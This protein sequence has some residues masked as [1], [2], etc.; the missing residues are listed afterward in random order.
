MK[1]FKT[2][3]GNGNAD[4]AYAFASR[5]DGPVS[6]LIHHGPDIQRWQYQRGLYNGHQIMRYCLS[7][8]W[9]GRCTQGPSA[10]D[11]LQEVR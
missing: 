9:N 10:L 8:D 4:D 5:A 6:V 7:V 3:S 1:P 2:P 11:S